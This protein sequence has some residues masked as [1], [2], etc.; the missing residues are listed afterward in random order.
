MLESDV[1]GEKS[2]NFLN[3]HLPFFSKFMEVKYMRMG[4]FHVTHVTVRIFFE[5]KPPQ[6][7]DFKKQKWKVILNISNTILKKKKESK[8]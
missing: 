1:A 3:G 5:G 7:L 6:N 4:H 8:E 2:R